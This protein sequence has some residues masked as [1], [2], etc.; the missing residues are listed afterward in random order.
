MSPKELS[1]EEKDRLYVV[2]TYLLN[3][4]NEAFPISRLSKMPL[5]SQ[6]K[7][8]DAF[9]RLFEMKVGEFIHEARMQT[10]RFLLRNTDKSIKEVAAYC[11][12]SRARNFSTAYKKFFRVKPNSDR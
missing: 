1:N 3:H 7:F 10:G 2:K 9:Y 6:S 11:G 4:L 8:K 5:M 12:Y